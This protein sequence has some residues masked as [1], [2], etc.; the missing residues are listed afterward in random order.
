[1]SNF[2]TELIKNLSNNVSVEEIFRAELEKAFNQLL[3]TELACFLGY[4]KYSKDGY[5]TGDSRNG[6]YKRTFQ[7][8]YGELNLS[9]PRDRAGEFKQHTLPSHA[10]SDDSLEQMVI[11]MYSKG[12]TT[13]EI[14]ELIEKM[15]GHYYSPQTISNITQTVQ[16]QV[17]AFHNR[18]ISKRF[19][20]LYCDATYLNVRRDSV[21]KEALHIIMGITEDGTRE[22]LDYALYPQERAE[23][24]AYMLHNLKER[25]LEQIL[26]FVTDG[27]TGI[28]EELLQVFPKAKH[29]TCWAHL[30]RNVM[31][32]VRAKDKLQ[33]MQ[34]FKR[35]HEQKNAEDAMTELVRFCEKYGK[36]YPKLV[37]RFLYCI[38]VIIL[39][40]IFRQ[41]TFSRRIVRIRVF[42]PL[43]FT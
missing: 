25:G 19:V 26:L 38:V 35:I 17:S 18:S 8:K 40:L 13:R 32:Y 16:E 5:N 41:R 1:M 34:D 36:V 24:Y 27:L 42:H 6:Y 4:E 2:T 15:Y 12:V 9:I 21:E 33:V 20:V 3:E 37:E 22:V 10:R 43:F 29:Q 31:K 7:T 30:A 14:A 23:N 39:S 28:R 11:L